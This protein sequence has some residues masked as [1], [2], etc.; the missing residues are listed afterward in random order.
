MPL[1]DFSIYFIL[2]LNLI[3][4]SDITI[5]FQYTC[6]GCAIHFLNAFL[7]FFIEK[8]WNADVQNKC[9]CFILVTL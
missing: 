6:V 1:R 3:G 8:C 5:G 9:M 4:K 7:V 2:Y